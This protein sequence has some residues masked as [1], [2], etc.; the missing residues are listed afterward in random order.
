MRREREFRTENRIA[1]HL[2]ASKLPLEKTLET[3]D[4]ARLGR[5]LKAHI[6]I[7]VEGTF[8]ERG[9]NAL[10]FGNPGSG[11]PHLLCAIGQELIYQ[12]KERKVR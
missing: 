2:R 9:E 12:G 3:V 8:L 7:L 10:A 1:R 11:N 4:Q 6:K 5:K